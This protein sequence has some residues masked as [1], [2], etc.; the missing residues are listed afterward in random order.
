MH[1]R[2]GGVCKPCALLPTTV[3]HVSSARRLI[4]LDVRRLDPVGDVLG[5]GERRLALRPDE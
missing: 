5:T 1:A 3:P 4:R 2:A